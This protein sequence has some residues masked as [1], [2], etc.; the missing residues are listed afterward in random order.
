VLLA[1]L[2]ARAEPTMV[3]A[4]PERPILGPSVAKGVVLWS[5]G[6]GR[7]GSLSPNPFYLEALALS[8]WDVYRLNRHSSEDATRLGAPALAERADALRAEGY[9]RVVLAGQSVGGWQALAA[10]ARTDAVEAVVATAPAGHGKRGVSDKWRLNASK[11]YGLLETMHPARVM[12]FFFAGDDF[13]PG[14]RGKEAAA[15]LKA[16]GLRHVIVDSPP[17]LRGHDVASSAGFAREFASCIAAFIA[18]DPADDDVRCDEPPPKL[19]ALGIPLPKNF[20]PAKPAADLPAGVARYAGV[21]FGH[22]TD[23]REIVFAPTR[24][25]AD[26]VEAVYA[27]GRVNSAAERSSGATVRRGVFAENCLVFDEEG[28]PRLTYRARADGRLDATW[29]A[30]DKSATLTGV[31]ARIE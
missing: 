4:W 7:G 16:R 13:D 27:F 15:I 19:D 1:P 20:A 26:E 25:A 17:G 8:G 29:E 5:H 22:Y 18:A 31:L 12:L 30:Y 9:R 3:A 11:L 6:G 2:L 10:A 24:F 23:G 28:R 21:W 14:G